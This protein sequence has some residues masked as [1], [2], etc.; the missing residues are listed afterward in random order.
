VLEGFV[1][2]SV[3]VPSLVVVLGASVVRPVDAASD[4]SWV[5]RR[6]S[7]SVDSVELAVVERGSASEVL[8]GLEDVL[9]SVAEVVVDVGSSLGSR[10][11]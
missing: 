3:V 4:D 11:L 5:V 10:G 9:A 6:G 7:V 1:T 8:V 2:L